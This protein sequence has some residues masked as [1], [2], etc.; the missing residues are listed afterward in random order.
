[1]SDGPIQVALSTGRCRAHPGRC[2][3][4]PIDSR[5][6]GR[7]KWPAWL[8]PQAAEADLLKSSPLGSLMVYKV[9][10]ARGKAESAVVVT[11]FALGG[12]RHHLRPSVLSR[13][14]IDSGH[15]I[16]RGCLMHHVSCAR[17]G[18]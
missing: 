15:D 7:S 9:E 13:H 8:D 16:P 17:N 6:I 11:I 10:T 1:V 5:G 14:L 4:H 18:L 3:A 2:R 12:A